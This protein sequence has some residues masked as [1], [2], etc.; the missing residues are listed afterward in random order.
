MVLEHSRPTFRYVHKNHITS[1][2]LL[3][4]T[5][6][7][8]ATMRSLVLNYANE[9]HMRSSHCYSKIWISK[10]VPTFTSPLSTGWPNANELFN[11][12]GVKVIPHTVS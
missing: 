2:K 10:E 12:T 7:Y 4:S 8:C 11:K 3:L 6:V 9:T 5:K 1:Y